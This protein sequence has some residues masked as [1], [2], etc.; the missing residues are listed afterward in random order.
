MC[1]PESRGFGIAL[2]LSCSRCNDL[3]LQRRVLEYPPV[4]SELMMLFS[5][6][7]RTACKA[8][9]LSFSLDPEGMSLSGDEGSGTDRLQGTTGKR[10][11]QG[12]R[13]LNSTKV[14]AAVEPL[15]Q[16]LSA[17]HGPPRRSSL[18]RLCGAFT[19]E[20]AALQSPPS[21][22]V[23][24]GAWHPLCHTHL[25]RVCANEGCANPVSHLVPVLQVSLQPIPPWTP[26][27]H[28]MLRP[29]RVC[30]TAAGRD[31]VH[32]AQGC[33]THM[34]VHTPAPTGVHA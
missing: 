15:C 34:L 25:C 4:M 18:F 3:Y 24:L 32:P 16:L 28:A 19:C 6:G 2:L 13:E 10:E 7:Y 26:V 1:D 29:A 23:A 21:P 20:T 9:V 30:N 5:L 33:A 27:K 14:R 8:G 11:H 22:T 17:A 12:G 31:S